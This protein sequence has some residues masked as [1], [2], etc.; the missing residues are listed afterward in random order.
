MGQK[1]KN[2]K[3]YFD[4]RDTHLELGRF[5]NH[6]ISI[7]LL[8]LYSISIL[9]DFGRYSKNDFFTISILQNWVRIIDSSILI[10]INPVKIVFFSFYAKK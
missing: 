4:V 8:Q 3:M 10:R 7:L 2:Q 9:V 5:Q 6:S 1:L